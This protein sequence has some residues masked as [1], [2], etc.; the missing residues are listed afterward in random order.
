[1]ALGKKCWSVDDPGQSK[2]CKPAR[3][4]CRIS[5][6]SGPTMQ[7][8]GLH[9]RSVLAEGDPLAE[10]T[11]KDR[12]TVQTEG[13]LQCAPRSGRDSTRA[14]RSVMGPV[15]PHPFVC[16]LVERPGGSALG[17]CYLRIPRQRAG[18]WSPEGPTACGCRKDSRGALKRGDGSSRT[19]VPAAGSSVVERSA[20]IADAAPPESR[21]RRPQRRLRRWPGNLI[22]QTVPDHAAG[23]LGT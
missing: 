11:V 3:K 6:C 8:I 13:A 9:I 17:A 4:R 20:S 16:R 23:T 19:R 14:S 1:M 10:A 12:L 7:N 15:P 2:G 5:S 21:S 22:G 18:N